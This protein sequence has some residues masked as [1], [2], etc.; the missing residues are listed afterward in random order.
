MGHQW[1]GLRLHK[2]V[3]VP[4]AQDQPVVSSDLQP[5]PV[6]MQQLMRMQLPIVVLSRKQAE[7]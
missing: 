3:L 5:S 1:M 2:P 7:P 6:G 4:S